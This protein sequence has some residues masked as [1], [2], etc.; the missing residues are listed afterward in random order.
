MNQVL[1]ELHVASVLYDV[2]NRDERHE[3]EVWLHRRL[4]WERRL[5]ELRNRSRDL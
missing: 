1:A 5:D 3:A 2:R 4:R